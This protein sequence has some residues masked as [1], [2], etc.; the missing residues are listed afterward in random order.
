MV[1]TKMKFASKLNGENLTID[2]YPI[3]KKQQQKDT[4]K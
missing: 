3:T 4:Q 2:R 1:V